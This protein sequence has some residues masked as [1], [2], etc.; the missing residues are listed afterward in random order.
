MY[1]LSDSATM[2]ILDTLFI[3]FE[4]MCKITT[5]YEINLKYFFVQMFTEL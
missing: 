4:Y 1:L 5:N 2:S 3:L